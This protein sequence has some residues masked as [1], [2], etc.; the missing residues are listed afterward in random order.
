M[1][2]EEKTK[3]E[4]GFEEEKPKNEEKSIKEEKPQSTDHTDHLK[5]VILAL[6][7]LIIILFIFGLGIFIGATKARFS[8][9]WAENYHKNFGGP[10][11]GFMGGFPGFPD[12]DFIEGHGTFGEIIKINDAD[13]VIKGRD[14]VEKIILI[15]KDTVIKKGKKTIKKEDLK[16]GNAI[17]VIGNPDNQGRIEAELIRV[18]G[19]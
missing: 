4:V 5:R 2:L 13:L 7:G 6:C 19:F 8:Y 1:S 9:R 3:A 12:R 14:D 15:T 16:V 11:G 18:F 10:R 17:T